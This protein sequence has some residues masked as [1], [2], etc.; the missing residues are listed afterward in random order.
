MGAKWGEI[1]TWTEG[2]AKAL[3]GTAQTAQQ[4]WLTKR[5]PEEMAAYAAASREAAAVL[6]RHM[7]AWRMRDAEARALEAELA[8]KVAPIRP[9][10]S[11]PPLRLAR[12]G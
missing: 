2:K 1:I 10:S 11:R 7:D 8:S 12:K 5:W 6:E 3:Q 9:P 4:E